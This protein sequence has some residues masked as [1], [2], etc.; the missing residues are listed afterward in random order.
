MRILGIGVGT[1]FTDTV[2]SNGVQKCCN[3]AAL[4]LC[5]VVSYK[6]YSDVYRV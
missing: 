2:K 5:F 4:F 3:F 6:S 1:S